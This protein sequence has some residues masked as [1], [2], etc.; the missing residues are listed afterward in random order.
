VRRRKAHV[1]NEVGGEEKRR[2]EKRGEKRIYERGGVEM[3]I[4]LY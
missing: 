3:E 1:E 4:G 2:E